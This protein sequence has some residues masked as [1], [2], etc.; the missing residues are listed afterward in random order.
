MNNFLKIFFV[1]A[2]FGALPAAAQT[3]GR[4]IDFKNFTFPALCGEAEPADYRI[5]KG[6]WIKPSDD[7]DSGLYSD[8]RVQSVAYGDL[9]GDGREEAVVIT[10]CRPGGTGSFTEG[11]VYSIRNNRP[12][13]VGR[14]AGGDRAEGGLVSAKVVG[15]RLVVESYEEGGSGLCCPE[16]I[17]T[18]R[19]RLRGGRM[20]DDGRPTR[21]AL[22]PA[23]R[24]VFAKGAFKTT[25][26]AR[27]PASD[28]KRFVVRAAAGQTL[29]VRTDRP[30]SPVYLKSG[31]G[32]EL[33]NENGL[34]LRI[35]AD[36]DL[37]FDVIN[38]NETDLK[39]TIAIEIK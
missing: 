24:I 9:D 39:Y 5:V 14:I 27:I 29:T 12:R 26:T 10:A 31:D 17:V 3:S 20:I 21:R 6:Q 35:N 1:L 22:Y 25:L 11:Y 38:N 8:F 37:T 28:R 4:R 16:F 2:V 23:Q 36:G 13:L 33:P 18:N 34:V 15:G 19:F 7:A 32:D 30:N